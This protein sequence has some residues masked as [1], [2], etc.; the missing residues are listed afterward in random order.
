MFTID[1]VLQH[2][3]CKL[4]T[5]LIEQDSFCRDIVTLFIECV[6]KHVFLQE[7]SQNISKLSRRVFEK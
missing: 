1:L 2:I 5:Y 7:F 4:D 3:F 6:Q